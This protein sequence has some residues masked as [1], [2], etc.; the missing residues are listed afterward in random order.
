MIIAQ[1]S[2]N[3]NHFG[4]HRGHDSPYFPYASPPFDNEGPANRAPPSASGPLPPAIAPTPAPGMFFCAPHAPVGTRSRRIA[5]VTRAGYRGTDARNP[6][7]PPAGANEK[8]M[9]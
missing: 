5:V 8:P 2:V 4:A 6:G 9:P 7:Q 1:L 3:R